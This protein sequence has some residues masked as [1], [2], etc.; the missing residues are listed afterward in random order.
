M[1]T[2]VLVEFHWRSKVIFDVKAQV[3]GNSV[4]I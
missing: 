3:S 1:D 2:Y 4:G